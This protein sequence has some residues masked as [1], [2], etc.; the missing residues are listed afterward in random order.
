MQQIDLHLRSAV[1]V[2]QRVD[3]DVLRLAERID[4]VEQGIEFVDGRDRIRLATDFRAARATDGRLQRI[5]GIDIR[6]DQEELELG[7]DHRLPAV[8]RIQ[9]EH[10]LEQIARRHGHGPAI[11]IE[12]VVNDLG[13]R[14]G[15]PGH[16]ANGARI[17]FQDDI[18]LRRAD[19]TIVVGI[20]AGDSLQKDALRQTHALVFRELRGGHDLAPRHAGHVRD[21]RFDFR[22]SM[23]FEELLD[24]AHT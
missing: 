10:M 15:G 8:L 14:L 11:R 21:D 17:R 4:V 13:G 5:V 23:F 24:G 7:C 12:A 19:R 16:D 3:R 18:D 22:D 20:F 6:L 2:D 1:F 9:L